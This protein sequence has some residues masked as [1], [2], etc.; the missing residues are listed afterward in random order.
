MYG[1]VFCHG[2]VHFFDETGLRK[3]GF[4]YFCKRADNIARSG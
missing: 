1:P 4:S 2:H 3:G